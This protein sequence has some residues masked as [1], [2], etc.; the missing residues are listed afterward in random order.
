MSNVRHRGVAD[1]NAT[2]EKSDK[3]SRDDLVVPGT[4]DFH[5]KRKLFHA[6][7]GTYALVY[8]FKLSWI[9][10]VAAASFFFGMFIILEVGRKVS[11][12]THLLINICLRPNHTFLIY[13]FVYYA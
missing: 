10:A 5:I 1:A 9:G 11:Y 8:W 13:T 12:H 7:G 2:S 3:N 4:N 6:W